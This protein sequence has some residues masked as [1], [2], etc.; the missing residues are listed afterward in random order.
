MRMRELFISFCRITALTVLVLSA[1]CASVQ[2]EGKDTGRD[3]I[4]R[5]VEE[6]VKECYDGSDDV[7]WLGVR[8]FLSRKEKEE[9]IVVDTRSIIEQAI[10]MIPGALPVEEFEGEM[11]KYRGKNILMYCTV[12]CRSREYSKMV[13]GKDFAVFILRGGVLAW[14]LEGLEFMTPE[15]IPTRAVHVAGEK[16]NVL[17]PGYEGGW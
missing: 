16:W 5:R 15:G 17:P 13:P 7:R 10:S 14:A 6:L 4:A 9:W 8:E 1:S 3:D 11:G 12:G 2:E